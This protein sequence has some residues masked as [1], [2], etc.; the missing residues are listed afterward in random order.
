[1][2]AD[3]LRRLCDERGLAC[4]V[5]ER[6]E[7][8][9]ASRKSVEAALARY[10]PWAVINAAGFSAV[11]AA[12]T[13]AFRCFRENTKGP[14]VL[15][16]ACQSNGTPLVLF[17]SVD[18]F[19]G[20]QSPVPYTESDPTSPSN[21]YGRSKER[22]EKVVLQQMP[23]GVLIVRSCAFFGPW[24]GTNFLTASLRRLAQGQVVSVLDG[25]LT[26]S[27]LPDFGHAVLDL[28]LDGAEGIWHL[29]HP[30]PMRRSD[31][32]RHAALLAGLGEPRLRLIEPY[33]GT[34]GVRR[35]Q[36]AVLGSERTK[37]LLPPLHNALRHFVSIAA[38]QWSLPAYLTPSEKMPDTLLASTR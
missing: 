34:A 2:L 38:Q 12:E 32:I 3:A 29:G 35:P 17:S 18:V 8:D 31:V 19:E 25:I 11:D 36:W 26:P 4:H 37:P 1:M 28:L 13:E 14:T 22:M 9:I 16:A 5:T 10:R 33:D 21:L 27:Y 23:E 20:S 24:D 30:E 7:V 15:A 6:G